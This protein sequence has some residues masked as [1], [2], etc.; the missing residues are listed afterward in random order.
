MTL[1]QGDPSTI[2]VAFDGS[3][4]A[5]NAL[6]FVAGSKLFAGLPVQVVIAGPDDA[7]NRTLEA[8][9]QAKLQGCEGDVVVSRRDGSAED[10]IAS[11]MKDAPGRPSRYGRLW[12]TRH[13]AP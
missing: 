5:T 6:D 8:D 13:C 2:V 11:A 10:V 7:R 9:A 4:A 1:N 12:G 3:A